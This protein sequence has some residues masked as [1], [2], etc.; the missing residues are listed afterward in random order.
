MFLSISWEVASVYSLSYPECY[1]G[2]FSCIQVKSERTLHSL[3]T[4]RGSDNRQYT[5]LSMFFPSLT[6]SDQI[7]NTCSSNA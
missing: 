3:L 4:L 6:F 5:A 7:T 2:D 1:A